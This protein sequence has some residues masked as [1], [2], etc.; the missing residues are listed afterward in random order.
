MLGEEADHVSRQGRGGC[1]GQRSPTGCISGPLNNLVLWEE[2]QGRGGLAFAEGA[3]LI[4]AGRKRHSGGPLS[5]S[6]T[7]RMG[8]G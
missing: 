1:G 6:G 5:H 4:L 8:G 2:R 7:P 3:P